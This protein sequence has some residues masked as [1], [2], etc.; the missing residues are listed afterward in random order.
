MTGRAHTR[1][2]TGRCPRPDLPGD[3]LR[4]EPASL[5]AAG[6]SKSVHLIRGVV[7]GGGGWVGLLDV[8]YLLAMVTVG[9]LVAARRM[10]R[11]LYQ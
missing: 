10:G 8:L 6:A 9:L 5:A 1:R 3:W 7:R 4:P 11:L 2:S